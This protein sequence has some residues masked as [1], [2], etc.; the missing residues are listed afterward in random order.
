M[1]P[2]RNLKQISIITFFSVVFLT[3]YAQVHELES[4]DLSSSELTEITVSETDEK[5]AKL[6]SNPEKDSVVRVSPSKSKLLV[7]P[8]KSEK[9]KEDA[10]DEDSILSFNFIYYIIKK[11]KF[12]D[13]VDH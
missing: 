4:M 3:S 8:T 5:P 7:E 1:K 6:L 10:E 2:E 9:L 13:I 11:F 12:S